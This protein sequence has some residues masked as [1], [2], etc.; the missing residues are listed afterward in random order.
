MSRNKAPGKDEIN[1]YIP[2]Y[3]SNAPWYIDKGDDYLQ[4]Q[5]SSHAEVQTDWYERGKKVGAAAIKYR[6]GAC[7]NCGAMGHKAQD[8]LERPRKIG[9]KYSGMDIRADEEI[10][11]IQTTWDSKRDPWNGYDAAEYKKVIDQ[12]KNSAEIKETTANSNGQ[13]D[14]FNVD[15]DEKSEPKAYTRT[16]RERE[17]KAGYL[18]NLNDESGAVYN[19][20]SRTL[21]DEQ[22]GSINE[23]GQYIR[24]L[25]DKAKDYDELKKMASDVAEQGG[26]IH[27][28]AS[29]TEGILKL[30]HLQKEKS[31]AQEKL[32][33]SLLERYGGEEHLI[34]RPKELNELPIEH[35]EEAKTKQENT[36]TTNSKY[37]EDVYPGNHTSVWGSYWHN[38]KWGYDC[39]HSLI[40]Q[41]YCIGESGIEVNNEH[42]EKTNKRKRELDE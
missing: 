22:Q 23:R 4:H 27:L 5:R 18:S 39:C 36:N 32:R 6:K 24:N 31:E 11:D 3:I 41:S 29:P 26:K 17:D 7:T 12:Y 34:E 30:Q 40:K 28:E 16:L 42:N 19:P 1:P 10:K 15:G 9:A 2:R 35:V 37:E 20:K 14:E 21:R 33:Q 13:D 8:C 38:F 25:T